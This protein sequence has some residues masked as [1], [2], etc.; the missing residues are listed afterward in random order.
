MLINTSEHKNSVH[1]SSTNA[2][3]QSNAQKINKRLLEIVL[4]SQRKIVAT[5]RSRQRMCTRNNKRGSFLKEH[6]SYRDNHPLPQNIA[7]IM[8]S[9]PPDLEKNHHKASDS[10]QWIELHLQEEL[11]QASDSNQWIELHLQEELGQSAHQTEAKDVA[12]IDC[13]IYL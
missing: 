13:K 12:F 1:L 10:N 3:H 4:F 11:G 7:T 2:M 5:F 6:L 9:K 8:Q